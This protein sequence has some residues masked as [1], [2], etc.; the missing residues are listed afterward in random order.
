VEVVKADATYWAAVRPR[1]LGELIS[2][3][4]CV[5]MWVALVWTPLYLVWPGGWRAVSAFLTVAYLAGW[6]ATRD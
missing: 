4:W 1:L 6:L 3:G 2:C 5:A